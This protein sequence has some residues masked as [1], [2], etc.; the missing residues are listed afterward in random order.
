MCRPGLSGQTVG[1]LSSDFVNG[2]QLRTGRAK[3]VLPG[4]VQLRLGKCTA[5][6]AAGW[7]RILLTPSVAVWVTQTKL[8]S[9]ALKPDEVS[10]SGVSITKSID[11]GYGASDH[12]GEAAAQ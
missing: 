12:V 10:V 4:P 3:E 9:M 11:G 7:R 1:S 6:N 5:G 8:E 2:A